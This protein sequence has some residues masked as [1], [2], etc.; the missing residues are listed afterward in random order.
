MV[1]YISYV[2]TIHP[3]T[4][5]SFVRIIKIQKYVP[6]GL[7]DYLECSKDLEIYSFGDF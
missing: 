1:A 4:I 6:P 5:T 3:K 2:H 7:D